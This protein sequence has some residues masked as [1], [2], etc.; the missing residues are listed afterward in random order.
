MGRR[1]TLAGYS[2]TM[3]KKCAFD[4]T[5]EGETTV[6]GMAARVVRDWEV[7]L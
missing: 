2:V 1:K 7:N 6:T 3:L 4:Y 5:T